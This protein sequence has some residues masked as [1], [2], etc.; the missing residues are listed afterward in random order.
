MA[1]QL[2]RAHHRDAMAQADQLDQ[3]GGNDDHRAPLRGE[4]M[5]QEIDVAFRA[6]VDAA[7]RLVEHD[8]ARAPAAETWRARA[9]ADCRPR[10]MRA[11]LDRSPVRMPNSLTAIASARSRLAFMSS[12]RMRV[13]FERH[14]RDVV[15]QAQ[16]ARAGPCPC[17]PR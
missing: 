6:D 14:Q 12:E 3:F 1:T 13:A 8:H 2:A 17:G 5:N 10:A 16:V 7:R 9:S 4:T 15:L 11:R